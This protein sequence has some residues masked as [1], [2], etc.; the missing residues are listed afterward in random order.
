MPGASQ[1]NDNNKLLATFDQTEFYLAA[2][3][4]YITKIDF[5]FR[6]RQWQQAQLIHLR[7]KKSAERTYCIVELSG[8]RIVFRYNLN[9]SGTIK[10]E[11]RIAIEWFMVNDG[12][13]H[14]VRAFRF[15]Q[16]AQLILD[17][18]GIGKSVSKY[19][20]SRNEQQWPPTNVNDMD[21]YFLF[22]MNE[23]QIL[24]GAEVNYMPVI[25][26]TTANIIDDFVD[27]KNLF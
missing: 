11:H 23:E 13:W 24:L 14:R 26:S 22:N 5:Y 20:F 16:S 19:K 6:T 9:P 12:R 4:D 21:R 27:G 17:N 3:D 1:F 8:G 18:G 10:S 15:G 25:G 7:G 2:N